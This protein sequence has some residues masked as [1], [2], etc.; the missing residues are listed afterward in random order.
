MAAGWLETGRWFLITTVELVVLF[1][2]LSFLVGLLQ[3]WLPEERVRKMFERRI[4]L[5]GYLMGAALG[6]VTP[7]CSYSTIPVLAGLLRSGVPFGP[8]IAFLFASPLLDPVV[9]GVLVFLIGVEGTVA[10]AVLTFLASTLIG[11]L[12]AKLGLEKYVRTIPGTAAQDET[13]M[14]CAGT[15]ARL[16]TSIWGRAW[17]EA[18]GYFVPA[19]PYLLLGTAAGAAI[20]GLVPTSWV[21]GLAG[22]GQPFAIPLAAALGGPCT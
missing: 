13:P 3:A 2:A 12:L 18:W 6:A 10:Y 11:V 1:L 20:Y 17:S 22:P 16:K 4:P 8:T 15:S 19:V 9:L 21:V 7:F 5:T 14:E